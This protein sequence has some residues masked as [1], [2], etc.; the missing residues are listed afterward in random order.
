VLAHAAAGLLPGA[1]D[2]EPGAQAYSRAAREALVLAHAAAGLLPGA[3]DAEPGAQAYSR[4][5]RGV[6]AL[7]PEVQCDP[8][9]S[10]ARG[11]S[12]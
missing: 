4:A 6:P 7:V 8:Q 1:K 9:G 3:K 5:A 12:E 2:A 10:S 11:C